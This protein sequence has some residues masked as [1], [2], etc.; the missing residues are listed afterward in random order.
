MINFRLRPPNASAQLKLT[1]SFDQGGGFQISQRWSLAGL[2]RWTWRN[3]SDKGGSGL[4]HFLENLLDLEGL[5]ICSYEVS[6]VPDCPH[7]CCEEV[8]IVARVYDMFH[9]ISE[10]CKM[11]S[12]IIIPYRVMRQDM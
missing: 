9:Q 2:L 11:R 6:A 8:Q 12:C 3:G 1:L 5:L 7:H 10:T 4:L